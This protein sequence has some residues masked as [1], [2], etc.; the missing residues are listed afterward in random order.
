[1]MRGRLVT[2]ADIGSLAEIL[3]DTGLK[4]LPGNAVSRELPT[5]RNL[6]ILH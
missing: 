1:M 5:Q 3:G 2:A 6:K 4:F